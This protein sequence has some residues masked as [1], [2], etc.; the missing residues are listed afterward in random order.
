MRVLKHQGLLV[1]TVLIVAAAFLLAFGGGAN[2]AA[3]VDKRDQQPQGVGSAKGKPAQMEGESGCDGPALKTCRQQATQKR[4]DCFQK[5]GSCKSGAR[6]KCMGAFFTANAEC[7]KA[8]CKKMLAKPAGQKRLELNKC[9][10]DC[11]NSKGACID[12]GGCK[13]EAN[14]T[15]AKT[16]KQCTKKCRSTHGKKSS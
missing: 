16:A 9:L 3:S 8:H 14:K 5:E 11:Q 15:C 4:K 10:A 13:E 6:A 7:L 12:Q 2:P 1:G